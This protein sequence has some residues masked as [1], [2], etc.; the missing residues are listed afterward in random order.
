M[1]NDF[2]VYTIIIPISIKGAATGYAG[3]AVAYPDFSKLSHKN[4]IKSKFGHLGGKFQGKF[5]SWRT[6]TF[7]TR[8]APGFNN[9]SFSVVHLFTLVGLKE[10]P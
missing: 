1:I 5:G 9:V 2:A 7:F 4:A 6:L 8:G 10:A 3:Y